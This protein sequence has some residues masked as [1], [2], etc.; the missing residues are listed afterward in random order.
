MCVC[1][2]ASENS[3]KRQTVCIST[4]PFRRG[5]RINQALR[6]SEDKTKHVRSLN[7]NI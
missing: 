4:A 7:T 1:H 3:T 5:A 6:L 2:T